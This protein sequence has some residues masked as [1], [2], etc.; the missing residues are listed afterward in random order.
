[1]YTLFTIPGSCSTGIAV[2]M[3]KL[4]VEYESVKRDDIENYTQLVPT[5]QVPALRTPDGKIITE[6]AAIATYL[7]EKYDPS[8]MNQGIDS[9]SEFSQ[10]LNFDYASIH[11]AYSKIFSIA[12]MEDIDEN[13][14]LQIMQHLADKLSNAWAVLDKHLESRTFILGDSPSHCDYM[15][16]I[17]STWNHYF[18]NTLITIGDNVRQMISQVAALPEF[19]QGYQNE[20]AEFKSAA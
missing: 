4:G 15:A 20:G 12:L 16:A 7:L 11:P 5:N 2:L 14:K 10:W 8:H 1:M 9:R 6:G 13:T 19:I 18:P 3:E 17:Y